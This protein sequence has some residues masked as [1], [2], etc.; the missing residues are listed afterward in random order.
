MTFSLKTALILTLA[1]FLGSSSAGA[2]GEVIKTELLTLSFNG[3]PPGYFYRNGKEVLKLHASRQGIAS[4][5]FYTGSPVLS[6]Y[7][8]ASD[9]NF[10][11]ALAA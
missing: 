5:V 9:L 2:Q 8:K 6:L 1:A 11:P 4:P 7:E 3:S 10:V